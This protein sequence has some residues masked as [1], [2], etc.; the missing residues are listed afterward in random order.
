[1]IFKCL[2]SLIILSWRE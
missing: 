2:T 1:M